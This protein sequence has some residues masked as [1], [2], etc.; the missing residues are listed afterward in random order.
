M[1]EWS[2]GS[3]PSHLEKFPSVSREISEFVRMWRPGGRDMF[4]SGKD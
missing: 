3:T 2:F 4:Q 1:I